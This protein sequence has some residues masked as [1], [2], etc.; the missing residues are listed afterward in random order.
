MKKERKDRF[1]TPILKGCKK[2]KITFKSEAEIAQVKFVECWKI[3]TKRD[4]IPIYEIEKNRQEFE[5]RLVF[6]LY[7]YDSIY[8][9]FLLN[10]KDKHFL[11]FV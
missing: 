1:G 11:L 6:K 9:F 4:S 5:M 8:L 10:Y 2:H 3:E 7:Y